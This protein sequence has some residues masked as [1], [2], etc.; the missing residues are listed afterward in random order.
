[1]RYNN[2]MGTLG[3]RLRYWLLGIVVLGCASGAVVYLLLNKQ[4]PAVEAPASSPGITLPGA[5]P[6]TPLGNIQDDASLW[7]IVNKHTPFTDSQYAPNDLGTV[8]VAV[9]TDV[10]AEEHSLRR[11]VMP[12]LE[13]LFQA[14][15]AQGFDAVVASGYR[16]YDL[17]TK[18]YT[19]YVAL[20][21]QTEA[22][23][24]SA[25]PGT[26][27]HQS[28]LA[29]DIANAD[30]S[31]YLAACFGDTAL[32]KWLAAHAHNYGFVLRYPKDKTNVTGYTYEPWHFR[33]VGS[34]L[35]NALF[36]SGLTLEEAAPYLR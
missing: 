19:T 20:H 36:T 17:Q 24:F 27:E 10:P 1:M 23:K 16:S 25:A 34:D 6:I 32:G 29:F 35:A 12:S 8:G 7:K 14:L 33:Y 5:A 2:Y 11:G 28:G 21:G 15:A 9:R 26:S 3:V 22:D 4:P 31:C 30:S 18:Y 13:Q